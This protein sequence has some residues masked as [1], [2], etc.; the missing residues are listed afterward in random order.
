MKFLVRER[1]LLEIEFQITPS[2][3]D[4]FDGELDALRACTVLT[5]RRDAV[6]ESQSGSTVLWISEWESLESLLD[7]AKRDLA[8]RIA[9]IGTSAAIVSCRVVGSEADRGMRNQA[10]RSVRVTRGRDLDVA[11]LSRE[12][13][14]VTDRIHRQ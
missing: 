10:G 8:S 12:A 3:Q 5:A 13:G 2:H 14:N 6:F 1:R 4:E 11:Q 7:F 9:Q